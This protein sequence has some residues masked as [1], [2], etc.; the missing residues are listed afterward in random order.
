RNMATKTKKAAVKQGKTTEA[1]GTKK[2]GKLSQIGAAVKV[3]QATKKPMNCKGLVE[4]MEKKGWWK[5]A[6]GKTP[7]ATLSSAIQREMKKGK[8][9]RFKKTA[10]GL[11]ALAV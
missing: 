4:Y 8:E 5:S 9:S 1:N 2:N 7:A 6:K 11:F 10:P 3:L